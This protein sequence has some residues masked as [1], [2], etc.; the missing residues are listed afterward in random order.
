MQAITSDYRQELKL[1]L[2]EIE[3]VKKFPIN[4]GAGVYHS[5]IIRILDKWGSKPDARGFEELAAKVGNF[6][7]PIGL[8]PEKIAGL[9]IARGEHDR[10]IPVLVPACS[11][12]L[13]MFKN[14]VTLFRTQRPD[15]AERVID[16]VT[17][18]WH[19]ESPQPDVSIQ[20]KRLRCAA[21][22]GLGALPMQR[23]AAKIEASKLNRDLDRDLIRLSYMLPLGVSLE[24]SRTMADILLSSMFVEPEVLEKFHV[25]IEDLKSL[26]Q[27]HFNLLER[28]D[29]L[30]QQILV[31]LCGVRRS[32]LNFRTYLLN[33]SYKHDTENEGYFCHETKVLIIKTKAKSFKGIIA[34]LIHEWTHRLMDEVYQN[35]CNPFDRATK[36]E[37]MTAFSSTLEQFRFLRSTFQSDED[38]PHSLHTLVSLESYHERDH[39]SELIVRLPES[40]VFE[41]RLPDCYEP[42]RYY[43]NNRISPRLIPLQELAEIEHVDSVDKPEV[44]WNIVEALRWEVQRE[45]EPLGCL[46]FYGNPYMLRNMFEMSQQDY[47][48][49]IIDHFIGKSIFDQISL[50]GRFIN[51]PQLQQAI[52]E[53]RK[54]SLEAL[55]EEGIEEL[56]S[57]NMVENESEF[58]QLIVNLLNVIHESEGLSEQVQ[59][60]LLERLVDVHPLLLSWSVGVRLLEAGNME[61]ACPFFDRYIS[62]GGSLESVVGKCREHGHE[63][64]KKGCSIM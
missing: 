37:Y 27:H 34:T 19:D 29:P 24:N 12:N 31:S 48:A 16:A 13:W 2:E 26:F 14:Y 5:T 44:N 52:V 59:Q 23:V 56:C 50:L 45:Q 28:R 54:M 9:W 30:L 49:K 32:K 8:L 39:L 20:T 60:S 55:I 3:N 18:L 42:L 51:N 53:L 61:R 22:L 15:L 57:M 36:E 4:R 64:H 10:A 11:G 46:A 1:D 47:A 40:L 38:L 43:W 62:E 17:H 7:D 33:A 58:S 63:Y 6:S 35:R 25:S 41:S 21:A